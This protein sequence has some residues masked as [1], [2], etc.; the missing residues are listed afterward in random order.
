VPQD[1]I[2]RDGRLF[3][4]RAPGQDESVFQVDNTSEAYFQSPYRRARGKPRGI[5]PGNERACEL[6]TTGRS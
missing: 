5:H 4:E 3:G 2:G 6:V 1:I